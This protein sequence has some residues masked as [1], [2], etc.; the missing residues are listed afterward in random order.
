MVVV[1]IVVVI[2]MVRV[3]IDSMD[4]VLRIVD[5]VTAG[6]RV[7]SDSVWRDRMVA[8]K[9]IRERRVVNFGNIINERIIR[10]I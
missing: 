6:S 4:V 2:L 10:N 5:I 3:V 1:V 9:V 8:I 7:E